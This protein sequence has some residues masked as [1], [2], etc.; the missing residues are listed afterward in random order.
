[1][2]TKKLKWSAWKPSEKYVGIS[3][4]TM[5]FLLIVDGNNFGK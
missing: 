5:I 2:G 1:M 4:Q 3:I